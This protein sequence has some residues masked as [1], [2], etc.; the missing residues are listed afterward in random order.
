MS[1]TPILGITEMEASQA[2]PHL[3]VNAASRKLEATVARSVLSQL[4]TP[5]GSPADGDRHLVGDTPTGAWVGHDF[6]IAYR[7]GTGWL[8]VAPEEGWLV[9]NQATDELL[10]YGTQSPVAWDVLELGGGSLTGAKV[11]RFS[12]V[13]SIADSTDT[14][15]VFDTEV[16][17]TGGYATLGT[18]ADRLTPTEA[19]LYQVDG[20]VYWDS[21][22]TGTRFLYIASSLASSICGVA[23]Q[24]ANQAGP[25]AMRVSGLVNLAAGEYIELYAWQDSGGALNVLDNAGGFEAYLSIHRVGNP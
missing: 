17:D 6:E 2:Q 12:S 11:S 23:D 3:I 4:N 8:F 1:T 14:A 7:S 20:F 5:P 19:G 9:W 10:V 16:F 15:I 13:Q 24:Q 21:N 22:A 25:T 18:N